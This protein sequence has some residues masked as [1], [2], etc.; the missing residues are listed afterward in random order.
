MGDDGGCIDMLLSGARP[1]V[2]R[3]SVIDGHAYLII[4]ISQVAHL[5]YKV[6]V[7]YAVTVA[8]LG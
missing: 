5:L 3:I 1:C 2:N 7:I 4:K 8:Y 6:K